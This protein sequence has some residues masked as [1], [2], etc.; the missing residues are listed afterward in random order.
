MSAMKKATNFM[1]EKVST[2]GGYVWSVSEDFSKQYG[3]I[4]ARKSQIWIQSGTPMVGMAYLDAYDVTRD[5]V[6][7]DAA[8]K[9]ADAL[10]Y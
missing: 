8:R 1:T 6:F 3:E 10:V 2:R 5:K 9:A 7:L 4:P